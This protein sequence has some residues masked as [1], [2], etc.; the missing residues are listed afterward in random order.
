[1]TRLCLRRVVIPMATYDQS[2]QRTSGPDPLVPQPVKGKKMATP[3]A[4]T[5][6]RLQAQGKAVKN[7]SG[8]PSFPIRNG[9]DL[10]KAIRAVG[11]VKPATEAARSKVRRY[12]QTRAKALGLDSQIPDTWAADGSLKDGG[13]ES[14]DSGSGQSGSSG[15]AKA[16]SSP[17]KTDPDGDGD[18]DSTPEGDTDHD[19]WDK[20]GKQIKALPGKPLP[21]GSSDDVAAAAKKLVAKGMS[22]AAARI[23]A[24]RAARKAAA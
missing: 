2:I 10:G 16:G 1:M 19:Y 3:D 21:S 18:D 20:N 12:I 22:P 23:F 14:D 24:A 7:A 6:R 15:P 13:D 17:S 5:M 8:Q 9:D 4:A 11:R